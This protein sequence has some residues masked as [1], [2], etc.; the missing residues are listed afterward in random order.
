MYAGKLVFSQVMEHLPMHIFRKCVRRYGGNRY[1][2]SFPCLS[3]FLC[4]A[5]AQLAYRESLRDIEVCL[6]AQRGVPPKLIIFNGFL[7]GAGAQHCQ[8]RRL[9]HDRFATTM[10]IPTRNGD[11]GTT[12]AGQNGLPAALTPPHAERLSRSVTKVLHVASTTPEPIGN[13]WSF[14][15]A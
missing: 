5:F 12:R 15:S 3:Q 14:A 11:F 10:T 6:R 4:M 9:Q 2:K 1:V 8:G 7:V 13:P